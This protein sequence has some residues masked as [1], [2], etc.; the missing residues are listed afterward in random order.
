MM[1]QARSYALGDE[2]SSFDEH[3]TEKQRKCRGENDFCFKDM[4]LTDCVA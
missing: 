2:R 1:N 3:L 4:F